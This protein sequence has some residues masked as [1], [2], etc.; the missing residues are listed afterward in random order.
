MAVHHQDV[1]LAAELLGDVGHGDFSGLAV[2]AAVVSVRLGDGQGV[3]VDDGDTGGLGLVDGG[4]AGFLLLRLH[5]DR[6]D[7][8]GDEGLD[9]LQLLGSIA[10]CVNNS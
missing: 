10:A 8:L 6:V 9:L 3:A 7:L 1:A 4:A 2:V 5:D